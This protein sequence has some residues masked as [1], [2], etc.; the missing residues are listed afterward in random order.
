MALE[1]YKHNADAYEKVKIM[2]EK[3]NRCA[4]VHPT[5]TGKSYIALKWLLDNKDKKAVY[6]TSQLAIVDQLE[7]T[8]ID[9][10]LSLERDFPNLTI[11]TYQS[12][13]NNSDINADLIVIDEFHRTGAPVW[14]QA[15]DEL[16]RTNKDAKV[17]GLSATPIRYLDGK[18]D[19]SDEI[20]AGNIAS[21]IRLPKAIAEG[22]LPPPVYVNAIYSFKEDIDK[23]EEKISKIPDE[24]DKKELEEQLKLAKRTIENAENL[25]DLFKKYMTEENG[26][27]LVF[28]RDIEHLKE[29]QDE[30][31]KWFKGINENIDAYSIHYQEKEA[32]NKWTLDRF[33]NISFRDGKLKLLYSVG[34]LNEGIHVEDIDGVIML[35][36]T[37]S[38]ILYQQQL[39]RA[40]TTGKD[41][42][43][44]VFDVVN[45][46]ECIKDIENLRTAVIRT[47]KASKKSK[48]E[49]KHMEETFRII[50]D[51]KAISE[52][53]KELETNATFGWDK[54][55]L[56]LKE[57]VEKNNGEFPKADEPIIGS[58]LINQKQL[59]KKGKLS[60]ERKAKLDLL[61][62]WL[63]TREDKDSERWENTYNLLKQYVE[64]HNGDFP[65]S[66]EPIIGSWLV[67][68]RLLSKKGKLKPERKAKLDLLENWL[69]TK[70]DK[71]DER[72]EKMYVL[73]EQ[74]LA[75]HNNDFLFKEQ[76]SL[77][78]WLTNQRSLN[79]QG[80]LR[81]D[82][83]AKLDTLGDWSKSK[84][85]KLEEQ[86]E[87]KYELMK[88]YL[89]EHNGEFPK[90]TEPIIGSWL[91][92]QRNNLNNNTLSEERK[93][94]LDALGDWSKSKDEK[95]EEQWEK[96]YELT[97]EYIQSHNGEFP[98]ADE[99][100]IGPWL[101]TQKHMLK[102]GRMRGDRKAKLD[103]LGDWSK[104]LEEKFE[105]K[106]EEKYELLKKYIVSHNGEIPLK[107]EP[108]I[109]SWLNTQKVMNKKGKLDPEKVAKLDLLGNWLITRED[110]D[111]ERWE[112][113]YKLT[114]KYVEKHNGEFPKADEPIIGSWLINQ[115]ND[116]E[117]GK[118][119]L[120]R[121]AKLD[122]LGTWSKRNYE[123]FEEKWEEKYEL[124][125]E[126]VKE[127]NGEMPPQSEPIIGS[128]FS[129][130]RSLNKKG[131]LKPERK[132]KLDALGDWILSSR[133]KVI[134]IHENK[135]LVDFVNKN[136]EQNN[137]NKKR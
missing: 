53:I 17:L 47:M 62:N 11:T 23:L 12:L 27:Y 92:D 28:C 76:N 20:F 60:L 128:W 85:E 30:T 52:L 36:K 104:S 25:P 16:L 19:M 117:Q 115:K 122:A 133:K 10:G 93:A 24:E 113:K 40:L 6:I 42:K 78:M 22:I 45:N 33:H 43:P 87:K 9:N 21:H 14:G 56:L 79:K 15:V 54:K 63:I 1:L 38:P 94:K 64:E 31:Q 74:Y 77:S 136:K 114:K 57:Y 107:S 26:K 68:Q 98:K 80:K 135:D 70:N 97:R 127:H 48:E 8:M 39:G 4:V 124:T 129:D 72:W 101:L 89:E 119:S 126:Y 66:K 59:L 41:H 82:R 55:Y 7:R 46:I 81:E 32:D 69:I 120:E 102:E 13:L 35:R 111:S 118:L 131:K 91:S 125:K 121:K 65:Q 132:A 110:K 50:D 112:E 61:G 86:W 137:S 75:E 90:Q 37:S 83:K 134:N 109:G 106:W 105:E 100:I 3:E 123:K 49:I 116:L 95:L 99:S 51:Y 18:K 103:L 58:W 5:G 44:L 84:N 34:M 67:D 88:A 71:E 73:L 130:Q 29:M 108:I 2:F 96:K